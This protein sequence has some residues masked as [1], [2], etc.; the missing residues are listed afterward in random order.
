MAINSFKNTLSKTIKEHNKAV[1]ELEGNQ[2]I[3]LRKIIDLLTKS[4][5]SG[6]KIMTAGNGG[7]SCDAQHFTGELIGKFMFNRRALPSICLCTDIASTYAIGNDYDFKFGIA[8]AVEG[9]GVKGDV[10]LM[11]ST[12]GNAENLCNAAKFAKSNGIKVIGILGRDGGKLIKNK[13]CDLSYIVKKTNST[14]RIQE[15]HE[16]LMHIICEHIEQNFKNIKSKVY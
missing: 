9:V 1:L 6:H 5:K 3:A 15:V 4:I 13:L 14:P 16:I 11:F 12:S 8:R 7:S 2:V 10:L